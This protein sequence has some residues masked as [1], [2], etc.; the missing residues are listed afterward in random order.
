MDYH[1][2]IAGT[3]ASAGRRQLLRARPAFLLALWV[4]L[5]GCAQAPEPIGAPPDP[6]Q[7]GPVLTPAPT[8]SWQIYGPADGLPSANITAIAAALEGGIWAGTPGGVAF[9]DGARWTAYD[10]ASGLAADLVLSVAV[11]P[12]GVAW[13]GSHNAVSRFDGETWTHYGE[14]D[15]LPAGYVQVIQV[16]RQGHVWFA[17][18]GAGGDW[19]AGNGVARLDDRNSADK[20]DD[21]WQRFLPRRSRFAGEVITVIADAGDAGMWFG[22]A[23]AGSIRGRGRR[24]G[25]W[26]FRGVDTTETVDDLWLAA[27]EAEGVPGRMVTALAQTAEGG[28]WLATSEGLL[29]V[30]PAE[31][32]AFSFAAAG[33]FTEADGLPSRRIM[34]LAVGADGRLWIGT[35]AGLAAL[36]GQS[37]SLQTVQDG[38]PDNAIRDIATDSRGALWLATPRGVAVLR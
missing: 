15:G 21:Q 19:A 20:R 16:D 32:Q 29:R 17:L 25:V 26:Q 37:I 30:A 33:H 18:T 4:A 8:G 38:L 5:A 36:D 9:F 28:V 22:V 7:V 3:W 6:P 23:P 34:A 35:D 10:A 1:R 27:R 24:A 11:D 14:A 13:F 2:M 31:V 12:E